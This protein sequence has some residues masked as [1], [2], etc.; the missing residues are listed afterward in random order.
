LAGVGFL[1]RS[2]AMALEIRPQSPQSRVKL[3]WETSLGSPDRCTCAKAGV[4]KSSAMPVT[5]ATP[6]EHS[7]RGPT[8]DPTASI[9]VI[10]DLPTLSTGVIQD[11]VAAP[12]TYTVHAPQSAMPQPNFDYRCNA[13]LPDRNSTVTCAGSSARSEACGA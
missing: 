6:E 13:F 3:G 4:P 1:F 11:R 5:L 7:E 9:V 8:V 10:A 2:D 12:S